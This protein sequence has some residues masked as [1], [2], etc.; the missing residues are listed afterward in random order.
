MKFDSKTIVGLPVKIARDLLRHLNR[1]RIDA[2]SVLA[3][4]NDEKWRSAV[5]AACEADPRTPKDLRQIRPDQRRDYCKI[6]RFKFTPIKVAEATRV[7]AALLAEGYLEPNDPKVSENRNA[8]YMTS[9]KGRQLAAAN[10]TKRFDRAKA[11]KEVADLIARASEIN[12]R[13]ELVFFVSKII[14]YGSYLTDSDDLGD[15]DLIIETQPRRENHTDESHFRADNSGKTLDFDESISYGRRE[16]LQLLRA[17]KSR[18]SFNAGSLELRTEFRTLFEWTPNRKRRSEMVAFDW[19]LHEPLRQVNEWLAANPGND[20]DPVEIARW[21]LE[22]AD[23][24]PKRVDHWRCHLFSDW[25]E[26]A[27]H[28]LLPYW[29]VTPS[30]AAAEMAHRTLWE[31]YR[32]E[33]AD[34]ITREY[35][36]P[37]DDLVEADIYEHFA[38]DT[39][40]MDAAILIAKHFRWKRT[41]DENSWIGPFEERLRE[42]EGQD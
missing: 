26:N 38:R 35:E 11:D 41:F 8:K 2:D 30:Q 16:V 20:A 14:A 15:I 19:R 23:M 1:C 18:L 42:I 7:F 28:E 21:C 13:D 4:L 40:D 37:V 36:K 27:A 17:R 32:E 9:Q 22:M 34:H 5:D 31:R 12:A 25:S 6:W 10:L 39:D 24:L 33:V 29:G 3:F